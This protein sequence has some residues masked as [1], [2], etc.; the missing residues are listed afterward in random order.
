V[1][2]LFLDELDIFDLRRAL[3]AVRRLVV[4]LT[5]MKNALSAFT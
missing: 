5:K 4:F 2:G 3:E 1:E